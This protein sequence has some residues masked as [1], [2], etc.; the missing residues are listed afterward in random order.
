M[1]D[2]SPFALLAAIALL[3]SACQ[4]KLLPLETGLARPAPEASTIRKPAVP[5]H[6]DA[7]GA[8]A[9]PHQD[10]TV[11]AEIERELLSAPE[12][13]EAAPVVNR[14]QGEL[15]MFVFTDERGG[16]NKTSRDGY[17]IR[18]QVFPDYAESK[19]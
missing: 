3:L 7:K 19:Q 11:K 18:F 5:A 4:S 9:E 1:R 2:R 13:M 17:E 10:E 8:D 6:G 14:P 12:G 15:R 16:S